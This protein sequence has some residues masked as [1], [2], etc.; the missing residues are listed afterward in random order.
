VWSNEF[1][2]LFQHTQLNAMGKGMHEVPSALG[3]HQNQHVMNISFGGGEV[4]VK[5]I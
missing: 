1:Q 5:R 3:K 4:E 2:Q